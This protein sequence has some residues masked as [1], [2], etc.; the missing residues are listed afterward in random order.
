MYGWSICSFLDYIL[1]S[2]IILLVFEYVHEFSFWL[3]RRRSK[4]FGKGCS[5]YF[6]ISQGL[7]HQEVTKPQSAVLLRQ[8]RIKSLCPSYSWGDC[9]DIRACQ[10]QMVLPLRTRRLCECF[11]VWMKVESQKKLCWNSQHRYSS[12]LLIPAAHV[13]RR[14]YVLQLMLVLTFSRIISYTVKMTQIFTQRSPLKSSNWLMWSKALLFYRTVALRLVFS[15]CWSKLI[16][17]AFPKSR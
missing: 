3:N 12:L 2:I 13:Y 15:W 7:F 16:I 9:C 17:A 4:C 11:M 14:S 1:M 8:N 5:L 6:N 10:F